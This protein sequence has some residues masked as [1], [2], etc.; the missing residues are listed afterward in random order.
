MTAHL[1]RR[2]LIM[3]AAVLAAAVLASAAWPQAGAIKI[4]VPYT[5]GSGP[6]ILSRLMAEQIGRTQGPTVVVENRP[7]G[8]TVIGTE[9]VERAAPRRP[10]RAARGEF[11]RHQP[12]LA[13]SELRPNGK[14]RTGLLSRG[15]PDGPRRARLVALS[16]ARRF[17]CRGACQTWRAGVRERR[18]RLFLARRHR[19]AQARGQHQ[20]DLRALWRHRARNQCA[21]GQSCGGG[22]GRLSDRRVA[23]Q[24]RHAARAGDDLAH[25]GRDAPGCANPRRDRD[26]Q[27]RGGYLLWHRGAGED[28]GRDAQSALRLLQQRD[29]SPRHGAKT[30]RT[31]AVSDRHV[32]GRIRRLPA[33]NGRRLQP[34]HSRR[35]YNGE[36]G[37]CRVFRFRGNER[38]L[39]RGCGRVM[40]SGQSSG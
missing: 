13:A 25:G 36:I 5:P 21:D 14:L 29:Q 6:D 26:Q 7:G 20:L 8:G 10:Y 39:P 16:Y 4:V 38:T 22:V 1:L 11:V 40:D 28:A 33:T 30:R 34:H 18:A 15:N 9:A 37:P 32:R 23:A 27:L 24:S 2:L 12:A 31:R 19:G 35:E 17:D 3:V